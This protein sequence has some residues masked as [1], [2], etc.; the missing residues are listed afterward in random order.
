VPRGYRHRRRRSLRRPKNRTAAVRSGQRRF[1][2]RVKGLEPHP[3]AG[4]STLARGGAGVRSVKAGGGCASGGLALRRALHGLASSAGRRGQRFIG[5]GDAGELICRANSVELVRPCELVLE[6][7]RYAEGGRAGLF[8]NS[9]E[10]G[11]PK[12]ARV[13][14]SQHDS[15][16]LISTHLDAS[17][18]ISSRLDESRLSSAPLAEH[19]RKVDRIDD[20]IAIDVTDTSA[21]PVAEQDSD[22]RA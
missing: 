15:S 22:V 7:Q 9:S 2:E 21:A 6:G 3:E 18:R 5:S 1:E 13:S 12:W 16:R 14:S 20:A 10:C 8:T 11:C 4:T 19:Q 17:R